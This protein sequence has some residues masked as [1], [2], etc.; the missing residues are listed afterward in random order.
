MGYSVTGDKVTIH[1]E[2]RISAD[3]AGELES[4][5]NEILGETGAKS[6]EFNAASLDYIASAGLRVVMRMLKSYGNVTVIEASNEVYDVFE[7]TGLTEIMPIRRRLRHI[8]VEGCKKIGQGATASVYRLDDET[9]VKVFN[10][11]VNMQIVEAERERTKA[12]FVAGIPT[13]ISYETVWVGKQIGTVSE[14]LDAKDMM[15]VIANDREHLTDWIKKL[16]H[17][18]RRLH[19]IEVD[20]ARFTN[21]KT[22]SMATLPKLVGVVGTQ[23]EID[24]LMKMYENLPD[25]TTFLH[26]DCHPG[27]VMIQG[28]ELQ[29]ID[30]M[31]AGMGHPILDLT[32][33]CSI[34]KMST[35]A[36][37]EAYE[38]QRPHRVAIAPFS[39]D[40]ACLMWDTFL[41]AYLDTD[42]EELIAK[43]EAQVLAYAA[44]RTLFIA[45]FMP[46]YMSAEQLEGLKQMALGYAAHLEPICF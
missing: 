36:G 17:E 45:I 16:A 5:I 4:Q 44:L 22:T 35:L 3:N 43:A 31:A 7:M 39:Y 32:S 30:L 26:G 40:E 42:D 15:E 2:G 21:T 1:L 11:N 24:I 14:M 25:C 19:Q 6:I 9:I 20:P 41:R 12:A 23:D 33:M 29:F 27:N 28:D 13:A 37:P 10:E 8:S 18:V 46:G 38:A 34:Y